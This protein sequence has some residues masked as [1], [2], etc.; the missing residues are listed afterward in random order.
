ML[1][2]WPIPLCDSD[3]RVNDHQLELMNE[4]NYTPTNDT[5]ERSP[6]SFELYRPIP[7]RANDHPITSQMQ[8]Y[9]YQHVTFLEF[10]VNVDQEF[11]KKKR[12]RKY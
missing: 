4:F 9:V 7:I 3:L 1:E 12:K 5:N 11:G 10:I 8:E 2:V 6:K